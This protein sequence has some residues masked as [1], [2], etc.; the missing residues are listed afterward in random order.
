MIY[1]LAES[2]TQTPRELLPG[3]Y[4]E[5]NLSDDGGQ[6]NPRVKVE[7]TK[8]IFLYI[9]NFDARRKAVLKHDVHHIAT[10]YTST[11]KGET[12]IGAWEIASGVRHYWVAFVLDMSGMMTGMLFNPLGV[13]KAFV[14][15]RRTKNLYSDN[16]TDEQ[17]MNTPLSTIKD[18]LL[19]NTYPGNKLGN[20]ADLFLFILL[21]LF[22]IIYS[23][24]SL[25]LLPFVLLYTLYVIVSNKKK[26]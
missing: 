23:A 7:L 25:L 6:S 11:F 2:A 8:K 22:G 19:L 24:L 1:S 5:Y 15:G 12:E 10:G 13:Y 21:I 18:N 9:P 17:I 16:L 26:N 4:K 20:V 3:F 14:R